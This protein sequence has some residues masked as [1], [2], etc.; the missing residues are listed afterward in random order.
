ME[1]FRHPDA[2]MEQ[3][4]LLSRM[5]LLFEASV[6]VLAQDSLGG[7]MQTVADV[8]RDVTNGRIATT[9]HGYL[10]GKFRVGA[11]SRAAGVPDCPPGEVF[12]V[13]RGGV[14]LT[15]MKDRPSIRYT[16]AE[17]RAH[18]AWRGLPW[19]HFELRGI[20]GARLTGPGGE[21]VGLIMVTD[22]EGGADFTPEDEA[23]LSQLAAITSLGLTHV[24]GKEEMER[25]VAERT[26]E[27][28]RANQAL[29]RGQE[30]LI[31]IARELER[32][33]RELTDF[34]FV[35]S[36]DL[37]EPLRKIRSFGDRLRSRLEG[38]D[39]VSADYLARMES[40]ALR[41]QNFIA[42]LLDFSRITTRAQPFVPVDLNDALEEALS[43]L[44][45]LVQQSGGRVEAAGRLPVIQA[46]PGQM[47][48]LFQNLLGN[49]LKF[50]L[51]GVAPE[52]KVRAEV[53]ATDCPE[54]LVRIVV[55]DNG[56]GLDEKNAERI[57]VPFQRLH[58]RGEYEGTGIG[59][60]ICKKIAERHDGRIE[61]SSRPGEG[62]SFSIILP[63]RM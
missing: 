35:A 58:G 19:G 41:M 40:A 23:L 25:R 55:K 39:P 14:Y 12:A 16:D 3:E 21:A 53:L 33:N 34:A 28:T 62:A 47:V 56:I 26:E 24:A 1:L 17:M 2:P 13:Q 50:H 8:A 32:S 60:A 29:V 18:P 52:V 59:L 11:S 51:P 37:Q 43:N 44:E 15:L 31:N 20:L 48:Q 5:P 38:A 63:S 10:D 49:A 57:F 46:D 7:I 6:R 36:H 45:V 4:T 30:A 9:G 61:V 27:L 54:P 22:K 42:S